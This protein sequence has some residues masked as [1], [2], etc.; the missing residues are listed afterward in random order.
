MTKSTA[1]DQTPLYEAVFD[2]GLHS[3]SL[4]ICHRFLHTKLQVLKSREAQTIFEN[5]APKEIDTAAERSVRIEDFTSDS[6]VK[7][8]C[9]G[10][11]R[12]IVDPRN[13]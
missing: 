5:L 11:K 1:I 10:E 6:E 8:G 9:C 7:G 3:L 2:Q 4:K 12:E 13:I